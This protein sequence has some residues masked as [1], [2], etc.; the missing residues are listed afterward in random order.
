[1]FSLA[2]KTNPIIVTVNVNS[3]PIQME[4]DTAWAALSIISKTTFESTFPNQMLKLSTIS[5]KTYTGQTLPVL[6]MIEIHVEHN[7]Q[8]E[9]SLLIVVD[10]NELN[11]LGRNWLEKIILDW[12]NI[13]NVTFNQSLG[14]ILRNHSE[15]FRDEFGCLNAL[16]GAQPK[17][18]KARPVSYFLKH[19][20]ELKLQRLEKQGIIKPVECSDWAT[21]VIPVLK[22]NGNIRLC[23]DYKIT[24][25]KY[26][27]K[28]TVINIHKGLFRY[29]RLPF[30]VSTAPS[31]FQ[32]QIECYFTRGTLCLCIPQ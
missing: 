6:G 25:N 9:N 24:V 21:P 8:S 32:C 20:I 28:D 30:R 3:Q 16:L 27:Q 19:R 13:Y 26:T 14:K 10:G 15:L 31:I 17:F 5:L 12:T 23:G 22:A 11:L 4:V 29:E 7:A 18:Y 1:M 2:G